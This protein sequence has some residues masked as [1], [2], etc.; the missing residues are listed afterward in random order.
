MHVRLI[1]LDG[2][3]KGQHFD[4]GG[5]VLVGRE[6]SCHIVVDD[7]SVSATHSAI[8]FEEGRPFVRDLD[9][10]NGTTVNGTTVRK[11]LLSHGDTVRFA[12][13]PA[14]VQYLDGSER[15]VWN[16]EPGA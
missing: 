10:M 12:D 3:L 11:A 6:T 8:D 14:F 2:N 16:L 1:F 4:I 13:V 15:G 9:S 5:R 7:P